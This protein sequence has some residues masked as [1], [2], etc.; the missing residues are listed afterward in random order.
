MDEAFQIVT[1]KVVSNM[2]IQIKVSC[3]CIVFVQYD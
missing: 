3:V 1:S 2:T